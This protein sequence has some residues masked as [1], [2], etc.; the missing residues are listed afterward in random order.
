M[1]DIPNDWTFKD[2][3]V[4]DQF[5]RHVREQLPWYELASGLTA[6]VI[7]HYLP[8]GGLVYDIGAST[9]NIEQSISD[10]LEKRQARFVPIDNSEEM[11]S[12]YVGKST[13]IIADAVDYD[14]EP[15]DVATLFLALQFMSITDREKLMVKLLANVRVG[16]AIIIFDKV[17]VEGGYC[18]TVMRRATMA[19][20]LSSGTPPDEIVAKELSIG[21]VQRPLPSDYFNSHI[22]NATEIFRF[23]EFAGY[24]IEKAEC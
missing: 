17:I 14:Y 21:G 8:E 1:K 3:G 19:G 20:K 24:L 13:L 22:P 9:G 15:F 16:G 7:R 11:L 23:G 18:A 6:H 10:I 4:A 12:K 2:A 5:D